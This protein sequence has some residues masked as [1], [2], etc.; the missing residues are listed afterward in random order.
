MSR[1]LYR[2]RTPDGQP[3]ADFVEAKT[4]A[5]AMQLLEARGLHEIVLMQSPDIAAFN[6]ITSGLTPRQ[7][8]QLRAEFMD[9]P[10]IATGLRIVVRHNAAPLAVGAAFLGFGAWKGSIPA[11]AVGLVL[12]LAPFAL[13]FW[14][15]RHLDRYH[16][17]LKAYARGQWNDVRRLAKLI[18]AGSDRELLLWDIDVRMACI[19]AREE[20]GRASCRERV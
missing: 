9:R 2:A 7:H 12:M 19:E 11:A 13:Y 17:L 10:G 4:A 20:I 18:R 16:A 6:T 1:I 8:A 3:L 5:E 15:R 14:K